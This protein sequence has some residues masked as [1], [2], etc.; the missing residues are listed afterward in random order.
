MLKLYSKMFF[1]NLTG[2]IFKNKL[3]VFKS[4][5]DFSINISDARIQA[6]FIRKIVSKFDDSRSM[7]L[8]VIRHTD[9]TDTN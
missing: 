2:V 6:I 8:Y 9:R 1:T 3:K 4:K 5:F 7:F